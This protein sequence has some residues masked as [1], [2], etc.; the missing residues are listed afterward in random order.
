MADEIKDFDNACAIVQDFII[1]KC[2]NCEGVGKVCR[3]EYND[4]HFEFYCYTCCKNIP[5]NQPQQG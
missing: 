4:G 5:K 1:P 3:I 2:P